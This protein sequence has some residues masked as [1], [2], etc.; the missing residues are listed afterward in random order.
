[1]STDTITE[2]ADD[3]KHVIDSLQ[4][5][6]KL[7]TRAQLM[8]CD[9]LSKNPKSTSSALDRTRGILEELPHLDRLR[10]ELDMHAGNITAL[11]PMPE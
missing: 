7:L 3:P 2:T 4:R 8:I 11:Q 10:H 6:H 5:A 9:G 1:M